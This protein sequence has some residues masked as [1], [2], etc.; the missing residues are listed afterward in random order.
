MIKRWDRMVAKMRAK[1]FPKHYQLIMYRQVQNLRKILLTMGEYIELFYKV[2]LRAG[3]VEELLEKDARYVNGIRMDIQE[4]INM[5]SLRTM[6][7]VY[8]CVFDCRIKY[9]KEAELQHR[10]RFNQRKR[11]S[12]WKRKIWS[13]EGRVQ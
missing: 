7:E 8:Q 3:Y 13:T 1:F 5:I 4:E 6:E 11:T 9:R 2:N 10:S 12:S